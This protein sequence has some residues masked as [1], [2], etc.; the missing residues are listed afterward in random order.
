MKTSVPGRGRESSSSGSSGGQ[1]AGEED[2]L[3]G[4]DLRRRQAD[5]AGVDHRLL[6]VAKELLELG[7]ADL[8]DGDVDR[9][10]PKDRLAELSDRERH[11]ERTSRASP[12]LAE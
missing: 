6:H 8:V 5:A 7:R 12:P 9:L 3:R 4:E 10:L 2:A 11:D 1:D